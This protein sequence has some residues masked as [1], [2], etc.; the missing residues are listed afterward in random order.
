MIRLV[1]LLF[2]VGLTF[3]LFAQN[4]PVLMGKGT[5]V[6]HNVSRDVLY[7]QMTNFGTNSLVSQNFEAAF[8][9]YDDQGADDFEVPAGFI[10]TVESIDV[11]GVYFNGAGPANSVNVW[12]F[13]D[14]AGLPGS[15]VYSAM[16]VVPSAGLGDGAFSITLPVAAELT[17][18]IYWVSVQCNMDYGVGGEWG[19]TEQTQSGSESAWENPGGGF[20]T[21]CTNWGYRVTN[22][23]IGAAPYYDFSFRLNGTSSIIPVELTSFNA[24][25]NEGVVELTWTTAT[26][27]N[28]KGFDVERGINGIFKSIG[29]V[30]G[31]GTTTQNHT[32]NFKDNGLAAGNY[33]YRLKQVDFD[34]AS[35][36]SQVVEVKVTA[37]SAYSLA[38]NY[39]N[40]FNPS[41]I[42]NYSL[43]VDS[44]VTMK[45][46]DILGRE[47]A[48]LLNGNITA[49]NHNVT[50]NAAG[51][52]SGVYLYKIEASGSDGSS[53]SS[54]RKMILTK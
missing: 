28:N 45:I 6:F 25:V 47:V 44:K 3:S 37:P 50:F 48:T 41:T 34:G 13:A 54:V 19:W 35:T 22:C 9:A 15:E 53:F 36:Y 16:D 39:P 7:E 1:S 21:A 33:S 14:N 46:Y 31:N 49:G 43:T 20:A 8:D 10:W 18:G 12:F 26:E 40:P 24:S 42:I 11:L 30:Q 17:E 2:V 32:Y 4:T 27:K 52:N 23:A 5:P 29:F 51:F 38:Q